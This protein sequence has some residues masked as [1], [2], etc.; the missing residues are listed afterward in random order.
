MGKDGDRG[1]GRLAYWGRDRGK[2]VLGKGSR[3]QV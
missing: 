1:K 2:N 3:R